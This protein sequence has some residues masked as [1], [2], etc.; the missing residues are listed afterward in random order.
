MGNLT[1]KV[2]K[3]KARQ[4]KAKFVS[5]FVISAAIAFFHATSTIYLR[6]LF[7]VKTLLP[8]GDIPKTD[9]IFN[10]GDLMV[11]KYE[12]GLKILNDK[13]FLLAEQIRPGAILLLL[14]VVIYMV[15]KEKL[16][17]LGLF[18]YIS[19]L[20]SVAY[21]AILYGFLGWPDSLLAKDVVS[22]LPVPIIVPVY[23]PVLLSL[24]VFM[25]G[26]FLV[27]KKK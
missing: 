6:Q 27:F 5:L 17:R 19:G 24:L 3:K 4:K 9:T 13:S 22:F 2:K 26:F 20:F 1:N 8:A 16:D 7:N 21:Y 12:M 25:V 23:M 15:G 11:L 18:L 14:L 10:V